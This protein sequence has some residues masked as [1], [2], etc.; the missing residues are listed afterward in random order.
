MIGR[1][2]YVGQTVFVMFDRF[3]PELKGWTVSC[4]V[5][6][7]EICC[8]TDRRFSSCYVCTYGRTDIAILISVPQRREGVRI[9]SV[10]GILPC[11][12]LVTKRCENS[13]PSSKVETVGLRDTRTVWRSLK[14]TFFFFIS[15]LK[16][17]TYWCPRVGFDP[18]IPLFRWSKDERI[19][20]IGH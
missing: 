7:Y 12:C 13:S 11:A 3:Y 19:R 4:K 1:P 2:L 8:S 17:K 18:I 9:C 10:W 14:P 15:S 5:F 16:K 20:V 6:R